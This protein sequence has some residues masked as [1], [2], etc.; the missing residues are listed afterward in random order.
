V[1]LVLKT[2]VSPLIIEGLVALLMCTLMTAIVLLPCTGAI[3]EETTRLHRLQMETHSFRF[4]KDSLEA[5]D[6]VFMV[7]ITFKNVEGT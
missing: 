5:V 7:F 3:V 6:Q 4:I 1:L 2:V